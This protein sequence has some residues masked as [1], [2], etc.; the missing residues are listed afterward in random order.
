MLIITSKTI[1]S[2]VRKSLTISTRLRPANNL[3]ASIRPTPLSFTI[4]G[5]SIYNLDQDLTIG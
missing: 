3:S 2:N 4:A 1:E 5:G